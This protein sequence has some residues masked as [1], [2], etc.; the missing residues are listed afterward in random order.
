M[1]F[2]MRFVRFF[3]L[4]L[5]LVANWTGPVC[6]AETLTI[7]SG[8]GY[9]RLVDQAC[10][11]FTAKTGIQ[12]Q[13]VF[14]N[15]GQVV[16][17]VRESGNF[18]FILGDKAHLESTGLA[19]SGEYVFG[20]GKLVAA[21]A[22]GSKITN[23]DQLT[24]VTDNRVAIADPKKA[25]SG[26]A[27][28]EYLKNKGIWEKMQPKLLVVGTVPQVSAYVLTSEVDV[29][30]INL[31][32]AMAIEKK[33]GLLLPMDENLYSPILIVAKRMQQSPHSQAADAFLAF[34]QTDE[35]RIL[36]KQNGL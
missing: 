4:S 26:H 35:A 6:A 20:K 12:V 2:T 7:A 3:L 17:Q 21:V 30:F 22:K 24:E 36:I 28:T 32:E 34:L 29:G 25:I 19:F 15:M 27:A 16:A 13:R 8:A 33:V 14:G 11:A 31:T 10:T 23:L 1:I 18:D 5:L 9:K